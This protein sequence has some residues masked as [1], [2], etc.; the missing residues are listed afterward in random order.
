[1]RHT[2]S[3]LWHS[4]AIAVGAVTNFWQGG[5]RYL[6]A[7]GKHDQSANRKSHCDDEQS[8]DRQLHIFRA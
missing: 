7:Q 6:G 3:S 1:M 4:H 2:V 8:D 5:A